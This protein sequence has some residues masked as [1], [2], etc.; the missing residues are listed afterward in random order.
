MVIHLDWPAIAMLWQ[1]RGPEGIAMISDSVTT[2]GL[3]DGEYVGGNHYVRVEGG[4]NFTRS[5]GIAGSWCQMDTGVTNLAHA[6]LPL[7]EII[8]AASMTPAAYVR[9][10]DK[11]GSIAPGKMACLAAWD[12]DTRCLWGFDGQHIE[13]AH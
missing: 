10:T 12:E 13:Y 4:R 5:G 6:G 3:P 7:E 2:A 9:M 8:Q 1:A 11:L